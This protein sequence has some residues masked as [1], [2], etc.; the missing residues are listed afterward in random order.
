M[1]ETIED[2]DIEIDQK[3]GKKEF[4]EKK[5]RLPDSKYVEEIKNLG[6]K[7]DHPKEKVIGLWID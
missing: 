3:Y 7:E 6:S 1:G 4:F 5:I 2:T